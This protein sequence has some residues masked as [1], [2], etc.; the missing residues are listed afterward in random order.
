MQ[1]RP[2]EIEKNKVP[3]RG[4]RNSMC[5]QQTTTP[6]TAMQVGTRTHTSPHTHS[7]TFPTHKLQGWPSITITGVDLW[8]NASGVEILTHF[9]KLQAP[10]LAP[11]HYHRSGPAN[12]LRG[13]MSVALL[14][15]QPHTCV[16]TAIE[17]KR[18]GEV[19]RSPLDK[20]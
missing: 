17:P 12:L 1:R 2:N 6:S 18:G 20:S 10:R 3:G 19:G 7:H 4:P 11:Y 5:E 14:G 15:G 8:V 9:F 16:N 13:V